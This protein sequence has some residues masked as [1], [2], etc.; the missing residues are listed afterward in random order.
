MSS[1]S[2][3]R[4]VIVVDGSKMIRSCTYPCESSCKF[5]IHPQH[6]RGLLKFESG[7]ARF[8][9]AHRWQATY[10][11]FQAR[12]HLREVCWARNRSRCR[13]RIHWQMTRLNHSPETLKEMLLWCNGLVT[14]TSICS[15]MRLGG[16][17]VHSSDSKSSWTRAGF[18]VKLRGL[19][20]S[21]RFR[22]T[23]G[24]S[25]SLW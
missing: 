15:G 21:S 5:C 16:L 25:V 8:W 14:C 19:K 24:A 7:T 13:A 23:E 18:A 1:L 4:S 11:K 20:L 6:G 2:E 9:G 12:L 17:R 3:E 22:A 10:S